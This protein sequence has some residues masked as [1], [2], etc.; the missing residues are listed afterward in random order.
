[1]LEIIIVTSVKK[2]QRLERSPG[3]HSPVLLIGKEDGKADNNYSV[4]AKH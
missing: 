4:L 2:R 3:K 1:M